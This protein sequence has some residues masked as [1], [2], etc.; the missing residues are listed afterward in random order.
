MK[1][2]EMIQILNT[3][4]PDME[5]LWYDLWDLFTAKKLHPSN[6]VVWY[7][8]EFEEEK[9][10]THHKQKTKV[11]EKRM[12]YVCKSTTDTQKYKD[13]WLQPELCLFI[14]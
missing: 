8:E 5:V 10:K 12:I 7:Y 1:V 3:Y 11:I 13:W 9:K 4:N 6:L 2:K 14:G